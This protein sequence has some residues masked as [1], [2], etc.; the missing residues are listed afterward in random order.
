MYTKVD[1]PICSYYLLF[2]SHNCLMIIQDNE[3]VAYAVL[4]YQYYSEPTILL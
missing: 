4:G 2:W 3:E 1:L